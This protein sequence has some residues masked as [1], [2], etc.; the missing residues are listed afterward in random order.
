LRI[1]TLTGNKFNRIDKD[2]FKNRDINQLIH[3]H[4]YE[5]VLI[6]MGLDWEQINILAPVLIYVEHLHLVRNFCSKICT[7]YK[8][9]LQHFKLLK[10]INLEENG[11]ESWDEVVGFRDLPILKRLNVNKNRIKSIYCKPGFRELYGLSIEDN[12]LDSWSTIDELNE[13]PCIKS[14]R[15]GG[16]PL[17]IPLPVAGEGQEEK[18]NEFGEAITMTKYEAD[19]I[20]SLAIA[21]CQFVNSYNGTTIEPPERRSCELFYLQS[22]LREFLMA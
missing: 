21:R 19:S 3:P 15:I 4:L 22:A 10:F 20:H 18:K 11:I 1:I 13:F 16:N 2:F 6:E 14:L 5:V 12:L 7:S 9:P 8:L 17:I